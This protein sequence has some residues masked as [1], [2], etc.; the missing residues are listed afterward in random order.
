MVNGKKLTVS[1]VT[2]D[3]LKWP[4]IVENSPGKRKKDW[5]TF[6]L[7]NT[8]P[9]IHKEVKAKISV[10]SGLKWGKFPYDIIHWTDI[11]NNDARKCSAT[12][13]HSFSCF[14]DKKREHWGLFS[15]CRKKLLFQFWKDFHG[16]AVFNVIAD[17]QVLL[18]AGLILKIVGGSLFKKKGNWC[19]A[20]CLRREK[21]WINDSQQLGQT[22]C[23]HTLLFSGFSV[24]HQLLKI[25]PPFPFVIVAQLFG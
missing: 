10:G 5:C 20:R 23:S 16:I 9:C 15:I 6:V 19:Q 17:K 8:D 13:K 25:T 14:P 7:P 24:G 11:V 18:Y 22:Q 2:Y 21:F 3:R 1:N 4:E 12:L